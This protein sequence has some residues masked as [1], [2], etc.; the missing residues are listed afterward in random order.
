MSSWAALH[1]DDRYGFRG[2]SRS[3]GEIAR[4]IRQELT[5]GITG[6]AA[7]YNH[8]FTTNGIAC[9]S[10]SLIAAAQ[11]HVTM[12]DIEDKAV[13]SI[14][15]AHLL[16]AMFNAWQPGAFALSGWD[17]VGAL[18]LTMEEAS[19]L[20]GDGDVRWLHRGAHDLLHLAPNTTASEAG[21]PRARA[22]YGSIGDQLQDP[23]SFVSQL[24]SILKVRSDH[25]IPY[26]T[27]LD[28]PEVAHPGMLVMVHRL[29]GGWISEEDSDLQLTVLNFT[30]EPIE[31]TIHSQSL[32]PRMN[33]HDAMHGGEIARVDDLKSFNVTLAPYEGKFLIVS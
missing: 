2:K 16:L 4:T 27:L 24:Q 19:P 8:V 15:S 1:N 6:K 18:P 32:A 23:N 3:G 29:D 10:A 5:D 11:G 7:D 25:Y 14:R 33:V 20:L 21:I 30:S 31:G 13:E 22:L 9:T 17:L 12:D 26:A 28:I